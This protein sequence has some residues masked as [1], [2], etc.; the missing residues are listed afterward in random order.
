MIIK[1]L[2]NNRLKKNSKN[3]YINSI[4]NEIVIFIFFIIIFCY[5]IFK[6]RL[7][8]NNR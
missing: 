1:C 2:K 8:I 3:Q 7:K 6:I 4:S 5:F